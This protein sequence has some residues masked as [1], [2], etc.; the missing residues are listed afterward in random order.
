M[1][2]EGSASLDCRILAMRKYAVV[3][4]CS[5]V[6]RPDAYGFV[7]TGTLAG[8]ETMPRVETMF[9]FRTTGPLIT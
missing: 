7:A 1:H 9:V 3:E 6:R 2:D 8:S 4:G 5:T